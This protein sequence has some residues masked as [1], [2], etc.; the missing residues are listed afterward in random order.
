M[1]ILL[2]TDAWYPMINGVVTSVD[3]LRKGL[4]ERGNEVRLITLN[5]GFKSVLEPPIYKVA[6]LSAERIYRDARFTLRIP[7]VLRKEIRIWQ[8]D[9]V[10]TNN[11]FS[12]FAYARLLAKQ[13]GIP[14]IH[15][16]HT[17]YEDYTRY[18]SPSEKWGR[19]FVSKASKIL[20]DKLDATIAPTQKVADAL[21]SYGA[22]GE[23]AVIPT[24]IVVAPMSETAIEKVRLQV[25]KRF[26]VPLQAPLGMVVGRLGYEKH[27]DEILR[28][29]VKHPQ[30]WLLVVGDGPH[31]HVLEAL[32]KELQLQ[33]RVKFSGAVPHQQVHRMYYAGDFFVSAST[34][35]TQGLTTIE[36]LSC[37]LP[38]LCREDDALN[39]VLK[40]GING[41]T[42]KNEVEFS[43][44]LREFLDNPARIREMGKEGY[45]HML[46]K[47]SHEAFA[48]QVEELYLRTIVAKASVKK[49]R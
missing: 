33:D 39:G 27:I 15:T 43:Q 11:E 35:E 42:F 12:T 20:V 22:Q 46:R 21:R 26:G 41:L 30:I 16:Y 48:K 32:T 49:N 2:V 19:R 9:V 18:F 5:P 28:L 45:R 13:L 36:A 34:S 47:Y 3:A 4:V 44:A 38:L 17:M 24:G 40:P 7:R 31:R 8:P 10:H 37:R 23:I 29:A 14:H 25:R 6:S 1:K